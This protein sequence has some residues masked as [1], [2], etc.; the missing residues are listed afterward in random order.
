LF[1]QGDLRGL[2][3]R[4]LAAAL[5]EVPSATLDAGE[6]RAGGLP[7]VA[8]LMVAAGI[9]PSKSAARRVIAEGGAYLNNVKVTAQDA[10]PAAS[11]LLDGRFLV[12]RRGKRTVGGIDVG[13]A[14]PTADLASPGGAY[15]GPR[16]TGDRARPA[17]RLASS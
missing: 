3:A 1:G 10:A 13:P 8:D 2:D 4:T 14:E 12:L 17:R 6:V 7:P 9:V 15:R 11:D 5:A 16:H